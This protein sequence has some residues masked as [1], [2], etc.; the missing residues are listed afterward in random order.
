M[1]RKKSILTEKQS[2][3]VE[4]VLD[5]ASP[6]A[7]AGPNNGTLMMRSPAVKEYLA[8]HRS[9]LSSAAQIKRADV[10]EMLMEAYDAAK[11]MA[12]PGNMV[13]A[14]REV[15]KM[16]GFYEPEQIKVQLTMNQA[17][18]K[19]KF[20]IMSDDELLQLAEGKA[21]VIDGEYQRLS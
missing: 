19:S 6:S 11:T 13:A 18:L 14:A 20:E 15:G 3:F 7:A 17:R 2:D 16:L 4:K 12:E 9:E 8:K 21:T 10:L 1:P 5:G